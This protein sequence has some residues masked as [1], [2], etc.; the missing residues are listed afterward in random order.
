VFAGRAPVCWLIFG[1][2]RARTRKMARG[3]VHLLWAVGGIRLVDARQWLW[4]FRRFRSPV[5]CASPGCDRKQLDA[6]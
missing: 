6:G 3:V 5:R 4:A 1:Y 2:L